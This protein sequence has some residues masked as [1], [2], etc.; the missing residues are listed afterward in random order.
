MD[1]KPP[2]LIVGKLPPP[3]IGPAIATKI[4]LN[5]GLNRYFELLHLNTTVNRSIE[6]FGKGGLKKI[7]LNLGIYT[8]LFRLLVGR[9]PALALIPISQTTIGFLKDSALILIASI[10]SK[11]ILLQLRG[12]NFRNWIESASPFTKAYLRFCLRRTDGIIV[13]GN[14]LTYLF[15]DYFP[16]ESIF[17]VPNGCD[18]ER[19]EKAR[20]GP[21]VK[22]LYFSNMLK[23]KGIADVLDAVAV[24]KDKVGSFQL[25][26][27]GAWDNDEFRQECMQKVKEQLLPV[28]FHPPADKSRK[29]QFY[30]D[31]DIFVF[32][33]NEPEGHPWSIVEAMA[34][35]LP[36]ISTD[37]GAIT[38]SVLDDHN[39]FIVDSSSP[40]QI[41]SRLR[42]LIH[43]DA[44]RVKMGR[45]SRQ[46]YEN[47]FTEDKMVQ[48]LRNAF[49]QVINR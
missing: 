9:R 31:A 3:F 1:K 48:N 28:Y 19:Y 33:P 20:S 17:V 35:E 30:K 12:S 49:M 18:I 2:V 13:L 36:V 38:E 45:A 39:G 44:L 37:Q 42:E 40:G 21:T 5:S 47:N 11:R 25:D 15:E 6:G 7:W 41:A 23:S 26:A 4:L 8:N 43:N 10:F 46:H 29:W 22:V 34:A 27:V 14:K 32:T 24:L 16:K